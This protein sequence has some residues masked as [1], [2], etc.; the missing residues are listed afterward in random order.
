VHLPIATQKLTINM[1]RPRALDDVKRREVCALVSAGCGIAHAARYVGTS[2]ITVRREAMRNPD[3]YQQLR[4]AELA[5]QVVPLQALKKA[6]QTHWR[7]AAWYL[8]RTHPQEFG[9]RNA[10]RFSVQQVENILAEFYETIFA[11]IDDAEM[12]DRVNDK[13][14]DFLANLSMQSR[15]VLAPRPDVHSRRS[16]QSKENSA[17]PSTSVPPLNPPLPA[18]PRTPP[19]MP[20]RE[21]TSTHAPANGD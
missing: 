14:G 12:V 1:P 11:G 10:Q 3:F 21:S 19:Q 13:V 6:A 5:A 16:R 9:R 8:E 17:S 20:P 18:P 15:A 4:D 2:A 7:A